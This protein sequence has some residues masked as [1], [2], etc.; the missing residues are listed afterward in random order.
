MVPMLSYPWSRIQKGNLPIIK[1]I[2]KPYGNQ[3]QSPFFIYTLKAGNNS[4]NVQRIKVL[5]LPLKGNLW[6]IILLKN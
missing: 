2:I 4:S 5:L 3:S 6:T 1:K